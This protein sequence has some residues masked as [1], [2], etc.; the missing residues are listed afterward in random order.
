MDSRTPTKIRKEID[1]KELRKLLQENET[2][3]LNLTSNFD[4]PTWFQPLSKIE[5][6]KKWL[7]ADP[8]EIWLENINMDYYEMPMSQ[9]VEFMLEFGYTT[10]WII[11]TGPVGE[12]SISIFRNAMLIIDKGK[13]FYNSTSDCYC[14]ESVLENIIRLNPDFVSIPD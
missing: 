1:P 7:G 4:Q 13:V 8:F 2:F 5:A 3:L 9:A 10:E 11:D 6:R 12:T 14:S